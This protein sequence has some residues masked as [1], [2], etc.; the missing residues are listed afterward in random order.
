MVENLEGEEWRDIQGFEGLYQVSNLGRVKSLDRVVYKKDG[1]TQIYKERI[2]KQS[3]LWN[4]YLVVNLSRNGKP[5]MHRIHRLVAEAFLPN[6]NNYPIINHKDENKTNNSVDN[7]E[8]CSYS[9]NLNYGTARERGLQANKENGIYDRLK[10]LRSKAVNQIDIFS[11]E[12]I[13]QWKSMR[14]VERELG[15]SNSAISKCC[16]GKKKTYKGFIW[17]YAQ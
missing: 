3:N 13:K 10:E 5:I 15:F 8:W 4:E 14:E 9:Y 1:T 17:K 16:K 6:P 2:L 7:L 12:I 11:N